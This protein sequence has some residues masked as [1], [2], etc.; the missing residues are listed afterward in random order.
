MTN[1]TYINKQLYLIECF[2]TTSLSTKTRPAL[3]NSKS[4]LHLKI[5][6]RK[7]STAN[8]LITLNNYHWKWNVW[9]TLY[10]IF[11]SKCSFCFWKNIYQ[12]HLWWFLHCLIRCEHSCRVLMSRPLSDMLL[13][14]SGSALAFGLK[15]RQIGSCARHAWKFFFKKFLQSCCVQ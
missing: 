4:L 7:Y 2:V 12:A 6:H 9:Q 11:P 15:G 13:C 8:T 14:P 5:F 3:K 1:I 10:L